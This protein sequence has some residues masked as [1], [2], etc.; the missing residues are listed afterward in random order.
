MRRHQRKREW[1]TRD[2]RQ[3]EKLAGLDRTINDSDCL[4]QLDVHLPKSLVGL[5]DVVQAV[6]RYRREWNPDGNALTLYF[7][8]K[9]E[10]FYTLVHQ[11]ARDR[12]QRERESDPRY[13]FDSQWTRLHCFGVYDQLDGTYV[14]PL[15]WL[16]RFGNEHGCWIDK[17]G[18]LVHFRFPEDIPP[19]VKE[20]FYQPWLEC[21]R[22]RTLPEPHPALGLEIEAQTGVSTCTTS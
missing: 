4:Y 1:T 19:E 6:N 7:R 3:I 9:E 10:N 17:R 15:L 5:E 14:L 21:H 13:Q 16:Q 8:Y 20:S 2:L 11:I 22:T 18:T 12:Q